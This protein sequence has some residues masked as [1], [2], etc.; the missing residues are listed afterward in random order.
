MNVKNI[1]IVGI[2]AFAGLL[3]G[4]SVSQS[5]AKINT[6]Q[7]GRGAKGY[8]PVAFFANNAAIRG[9]PAYEY[10][11][12]GAKW[13]FSSAENLE[14]FKANPDAFSPQVGGYCVYS[15]AQGKL[16]EG[17]PE[18]YKIVDGKLYFCNNAEAQKAWE[19]DESELIRKAEEFFAAIQSK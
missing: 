15:A 18:N 11:W 19:Q 6:D 13:L 9:T 5:V 16:V 17:N 10:A 12:N 2:I 14:R 3:A 8:D 7:S 4:C 1:I